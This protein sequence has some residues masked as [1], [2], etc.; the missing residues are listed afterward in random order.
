M[1]FNDF[2]DPY[3]PLFSE[4]R[5]PSRYVGCEWGAGL[6][7]KKNATVRFCLAF[8]DVYE[9]GMSYVGY[10]I[11]Y[12]LL[13]SLDEA[14]VER[15][16]CPWVDM[17]E[18]LRLHGLPL[19]SLETGRSLSRFDVV[20]FTL[21]YELS[22]TNILTMLDL[23]GIPLFS[24]DRGDD[25]PLVIAGGPGAMTPE[26]L[27]PFLDAVCMG[28]GEITL[29]AIVERLSAA[30]GC[31]RSEKLDALADLPGIYLPVRS[32]ASFDSAGCDLRSSQLFPIRRATLKS[33]KGAFSSE[34]LLVPSASV[35]HDRVPV[36]LFRGCTR[37]C[38]FCQA[39]MLYRP[40]RERTADEVVEAALRWTEKTGWEEIGL[41]SL[42][43][44]DSSALGDVVER[45]K[46]A[47]R[48]RRVRLSLPSLRMDAFSVQLA[49]A[50]E[51]V[52]RGGLTFAP[53][54]G[55]QRMRN[56]I[57][58]GVSEDDIETT[59]EAAFAHGWE[60]IKLYFMMGLPTE[61]RED[62]EG[63]AKIAERAAE[64]GRKHRKR[65]EIAVSVAGFVPKPHTPFQWERQAS[66]AELSERGRFIKSLVSN[67]RV[68]VRYHE[69]EQTRLE[70]IFARGDRRLADVLFE[71]WRNGARF[72]GWTETFRPDI[73]KAA[74]EAKAVDPE[75][76]VARE[77]PR[78]ERFPWDHID[79]GVSRDFLWRER[80]RS[81]EESLTPDCR[82]GDCNAC[83]WERRGCGILEKMRA[84]SC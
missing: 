16:Y 34:G 73:W 6:P 44:C 76:Y 24:K 50:L 23:G 4:T 47:L 25:D 78:D 36:E 3:W 21:Q 49:A 2:D 28:D 65:A 64:I 48:E 30:V 14:D 84:V 51:P 46:P 55:T 70:G 79:I 9:I 12:P 11:L 75:W 41:M 74:F 60:R 62:L 43:S 45:L 5:R 83:G 32:V 29:P 67:R 81:R 38:R 8:P 40:I 39:G 63:I 58:K 1:T 68:T 20:G 42:A 18:Q 37:G 59:L 22:Y 69:G 53:E 54:A 7:E 66:V 82:F 17:E 71:A 52:K 80:E 13:K 26:P 33:M 31:S 10:Q 35:V 57:N 56:V 77:R 15:V 72:D 61:T 27:A 19:A